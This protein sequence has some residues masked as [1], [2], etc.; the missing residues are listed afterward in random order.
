MQRDKSFASDWG[1]LVWEIEY[2]MRK[3]WKLVDESCSLPP[4]E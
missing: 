3:I 4:I 1:H 2:L